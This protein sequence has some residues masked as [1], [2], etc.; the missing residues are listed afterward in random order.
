MKLKAEH[1][2]QGHPDHGDRGALYRFGLDNYDENNEG[3]GTVR[4]LQVTP[5]HRAEVL[6][7]ETVSGE[8]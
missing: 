5:K 7:R 8:L 4:D 3:K 1:H 6:G 2:E